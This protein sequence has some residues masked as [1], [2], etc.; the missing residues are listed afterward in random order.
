MRIAPP[1]AALVFLVILVLA[2]NCLIDYLL[3]GVG[4]VYSSLLG[5]AS[6][7]QI[8]TTALAARSSSSITSE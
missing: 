1:A 8:T 5:A 4:L 6:A 3:F 2:I 7:D